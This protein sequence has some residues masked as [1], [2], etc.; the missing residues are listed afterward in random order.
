MSRTELSGSKSRI[1]QVT[2]T[3]DSQSYLQE[4]EYDLAGKV[5]GIIPDTG[6]ATEY[7]YYP[8]SSLVKKVNSDD[9]YTYASQD[10]VKTITCNADNMPGRIVN[11][12]SGNTVTAFGYDAGGSR[13]KK[14]VAGGSGTKTTH[15]VSSTYEYDVENDAATV[16]IFAGNMRIAAVKI[17]C[18]CR[19]Q[20]EW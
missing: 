16:Y 12:E 10:A 18:H 14:A 5:L 7:E 4:T 19:A 3:I 15:Y 1:E 13:A 11:T 8:G 20:W 9:G 6:P 17:Q 2:K